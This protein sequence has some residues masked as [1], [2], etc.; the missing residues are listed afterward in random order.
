MAVK[1]NSEVL[2]Q[3]ARSAGVQGDPKPTIKLVTAKVPDGT[4]CSPLRGPCIPRAVCIPNNQP[5]C[6]PSREPGPR[7]CGPTFAPPPPKPPKPN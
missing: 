7:I 3:Q 1:D 2:A 6:G 5:V 4:P